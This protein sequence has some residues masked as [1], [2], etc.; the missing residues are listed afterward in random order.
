MRPPF[1]FWGSIRMTTCMRCFGC[2]W[3]CE[4]HPH[5]AWE[6]DYACGCGAP[7]MPCPFCNASDGVGSPKMPPAFIED[8]SR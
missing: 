6:G 5:M 3:V 7:G 8:E 4:A 2:R 1:V